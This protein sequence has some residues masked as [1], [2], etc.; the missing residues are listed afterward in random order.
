MS[1]SS[2]TRP[3]SR[4]RSLLAVLQVDWRNMIQHHETKDFELVIGEKEESIFVHRIVLI[5]RC[6]KLRE[7]LGQTKKKLVFKHLEVQAVKTIL[8]YVYSAEVSMYIYI[9]I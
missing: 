8:Q 6:N 2:E 3:C 7:K 9:Y 4:D 1:L 5:A